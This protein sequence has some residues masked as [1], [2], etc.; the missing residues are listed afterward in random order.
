MVSA[1]KPFGCMP[2]SQSD[3]VQAAVVN[4]FPE[5]NFLPIDTAGREKLTRIAGSR[6]RSLKPKSRPAPNLTE[7]LRASGEPL[8]DIQADVE[9]HPELRSPLCENPRTEG[10]AGV[11][12]NF[13]LHVGE[14]M[15]DRARVFAIEF[16]A[17]P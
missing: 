17:Q 16:A 9:E 6:W 15:R 5:T 10:V 2:S 13:V 12:A 14:R 4:R 3:G 1:L 8:E 7:R 11:A